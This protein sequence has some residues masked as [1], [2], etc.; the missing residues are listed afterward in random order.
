MCGDHIHDSSYI[1]AMSMDDA[2][3]LEKVALLSRGLCDDMY[4]VVGEF[5]AGGPGSCFAPY[6]YYG[7]GS[8]RNHCGFDTAYD[9]RRVDYTYN[10]VNA[11]A[12][13]LFYTTLVCCQE[14]KE[15]YESTVPTPTSC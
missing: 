7:A 4:H 2:L 1:F 11:Y 9:D 12:R 5:N 13:G 6:G 14:C 10:G 3:M 8:Y 15:Q